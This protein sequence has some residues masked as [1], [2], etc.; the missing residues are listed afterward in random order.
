VLLQL[1]AEIAG[2]PWAAVA[3]LAVYLLYRLAAARLVLRS[4][5]IEQDKNLKSMT[6]KAPGV[7]IDVDDLSTPRA[8]HELGRQRARG[9][10]RRVRG[11]GRPPR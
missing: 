1:P 7:R 9:R 4:K 2:S 8:D 11:A 5:F 3:G 6:I 10:K